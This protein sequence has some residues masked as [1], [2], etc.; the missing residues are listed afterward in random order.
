MGIYRFTQKEYAM[1]N[2][3]GHHT[4][5]AARIHHPTSIAELQQIVAA[6]THCKV[7]GSAHSFN[8]MADTDAD[9]IVLDQLTMAPVLDDATGTVTVA[10]GMRYGE[11]AYFLADTQWALHNMASLPHISIA[12]TIA[13]AT[14]GSGVRHGN[15]A[16][17]V[18]GLEFVLADGSLLAVSRDSHGADFA[19]MVVHL[20]AL[21]VI[22]RVTLQL[23]PRFDMRQDL[24]L[25]LDFA[26]A[27]ANF[28][29]IMSASY[30]V[31]LFTAWQGD[32]IDQ[33]WRKSLPAEIGD[34]P[35]TWYG[36]TCATSA[37]HPIASV[38]ADPCT[39]QMGVVG[40]WHLRLPHFKLEFT[41]S[42]GEELQTEYFVDRRDAVAA[43]GALKEIQ[44]LIAPILHISEIRTIAADDLWLSMHYQR[45]SV[46]LHFTWKKMWPQVKEVL[47]HIEAALAPFAPRAHWGKLFV[48]PATQ[49]QAA[50]PRM[51][52]FGRLQRQFDPTAKFANAYLIRCGL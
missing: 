18:V 22:T 23:V 35:D 27:M 14:H 21:G 37:M 16:T 39:T 51:A 3:S 50:Y 25:G 15:L 17:A 8:D 52:D 11:L 36:A 43:L 49:I 32:T 1:H 12:G 28:D 47:P 10:G 29:A 7:L 26:T 13:T 44:H 6:A 38:N 5:T 2:W 33:I 9:L 46:A 40:P 45:D 30:S 41:P 34:V 48:M 20:G 31:S 19:G 24:Y 4:F 42:N